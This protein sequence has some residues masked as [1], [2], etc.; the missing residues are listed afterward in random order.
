MIL[1]LDL[2]LLALLI[3]CAVV[4]LEA[5]NLLAAI[6]ALGIFSLLAALAYAQMGSPDVAFTEAVVGAGVT[7]IFL[8]VALFYL[9]KEHDV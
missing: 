6:V 2:L 1:P 3:V 5:P 7:G 9:R 4:A 8:I